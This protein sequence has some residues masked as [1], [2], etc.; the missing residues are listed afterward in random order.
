MLLKLI[1]ASKLSE[2]E[3]FENR[4]AKNQLAS[5][6]VKM[7]PKSNPCNWQALEKVYFGSLRNETPLKIQFYY[8][9]N[10]PQPKNIISRA[11][12]WH[13]FDFGLI[14]ILFLAIW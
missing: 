5:K 4:A 12:Q 7:R 14:F 1:L 11:W 13:R 6:C 3:Q 8:E 10:I 9:T 2:L